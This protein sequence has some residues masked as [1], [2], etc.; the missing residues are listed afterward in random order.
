MREI[1]YIQAGPFSNFVGTHFWNT[2][3]AYLS[4]ED[5]NIDPQV[6]FRNESESKTLCPRLLVF[7]WKGNFGTLNRDNALG[8]M[9]ESTEDGGSWNGNIQEIRQTPIQHSA[10]QRHMLESDVNASTK[11]I[12]PE[13]VLQDKVRYWS[14]YNRVYYTPNTIHQIPEASGRKDPNS[15]WGAGVDTFRRYDQECDLM[16][17]SV[18][19]ALEECDALQG[20][21]T[22][23]D[24]GTFGGFM[25]SFLTSFKDD[26]G[27][28]TT[29]NFPVLS[30]IFVDR[31]E[32]NEIQATLTDALYL[33]ALEDLGSLTV[34][35]QPPS[36]WPTDAWGDKTDPYYSSAI[37]SAHLETSTLPLRLSQGN[38]T[39]QS[40]TAK[41]NWQASSPFGELLGVFPLSSVSDGLLHH[42]VNFT[43]SHS[44]TNMLPSRFSRVEVTRG[45]SDADLKA[46]N[47]AYNTRL[48]SSQHLTSFHRS[49]YPLQTSFPSFIWPEDQVIPPQTP[50]SVP[51]AKGISALS[52]SDSLASFLKGYASFAEEQLRRKSAAALNLVDIDDLRELVQDLWS[53]HDT[54]SLEDNTSGNHSDGGD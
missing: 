38:E 28:K 45:L 46:I 30:E 50:G 39:L 9:N 1:L 44:S 21:Q 29:L 33:R 7:D 17:D 18:R 5:G 41:L 53:I 8:I 2:Q 14:D 43:S 54:Y 37:L 42:F 40:F 15:N 13:D 22:I 34:P 47:G 19:L 23:N 35:I 31:F 48:S 51:A 52:T 49:A 32:Y 16:E 20:L 3:E 10:Y 6:S 11:G 4:D 26:Y 36:K 25:A 24:S 27:K 12:I